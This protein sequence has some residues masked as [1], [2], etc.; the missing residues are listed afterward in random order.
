M[1]LLLFL[2]WISQK[3]KTYA[4]S[5]L[6][7]I[8]EVEDFKFGSDKDYDLFVFGASPKKVICNPTPNNRGHFLKAKIDIDTLIA[9]IKA[10]NWKGNSCANGGVFWLT[11]TEFLDQYLAYH[12]EERNTQGAN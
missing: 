4:H 6:N 5:C 11:K 9:K 2:Y 3:A 12:N 10:V 8:N 1:C 7:H